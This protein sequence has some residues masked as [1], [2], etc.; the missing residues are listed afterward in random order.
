MTPHTK[1]LNFVPRAELDAAENLSA[2]V[3]LCRASEVLGARSQFDS[4]SWDIGYHKGKN[5]IHRAIFSTLEASSAPNP[6]A[7]PSLPVPFLDFA[8]AVLVYMHDMRPVESQGPRMAALRCIEASLRQLNK[9]SRPMAVAPTVLDTAVELAYAQAT[10]AVA[11]RTAGQIEAIAKLMNNKAFIRLRQVWNHGRKKPTEGSSRISPEALKARQEKLPSRAVLKGLADIFCMAVNV[12]DVLV[13]SNAALMI[14]A[15]ERINEV[16]RLR[17]NCIVDGDGEFTGKLGIRWPGSKGF[18]NTTKWLPTA[19]VPVAGE[20][21]ENLLRVTAPANELAH[22][23]TTN[24]YAIYLH[25]GANHLRHQHELSYEEIALILWGDEDAIGSAKAWANKTHKLT[26]SRRGKHLFADVESAVIDL[27]PT[28]FPF[29]PGDPNLRCEDAMAVIRVNEMHTIKATCVCMFTTVDY[30]TVTKPFG[31]REGRSSVFERFG[32]TEEDGSPIKLKSHALRHYLNMLA[33]T[34]GLSS[35][36][37]ALFSG[38]KDQKQNRAYDHMTSDEVQAP[39]AVALKAGFTSE[40]EPAQNV[41]SLI[42]R[43]EF[44]GLGIPAA[45]TTEYGWCKHDF[46]S[47]PCQMYADCVN[48]EEQECVKGDAHKEANLR[49]LKVETDFL[50]DRA[51]RALSDAEFGAD[52]WVAHQTKTLERVNALLAI[53]EDPNVPV[54]ARIR[55]DMTNAPLITKE[56]VHPIKFIR[57]T[58]HKAV[59]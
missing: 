56:N 58:R 50:L 33:Q 52:T 40:L 23:Y 29:M 22:W 54:G 1:V 9:G 47:E 39:I 59:E 7:E 43:P 55:L 16:L 36:E 26:P 48:C 3:E 18:E 32:C 19:M 44:R 6:K 51:R 5:R 13:S 57:K 27:L 21:I 49:K 38:R 20:A 35:A 46:A 31:G 30:Q 45:H 41:R 24:R 53:L 34:G 25:D 17:R 2:F 14:C 15:P 12:P 8:K 10:A 42:A 4:N 37:I 11:Y 28:T